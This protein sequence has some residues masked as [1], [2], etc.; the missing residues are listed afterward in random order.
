MMESN[1]Y[2]DEEIEAHELR[3][4]L[5]HYRSTAVPSIVG[6]IPFGLALILA[7]VTWQSWHILYPGFARLQTL[8][9]SEFFHPSDTSTETEYLDSNFQ[10]INTQSEQLLSPLFTPQV[11]QWGDQIL[12]WADEFQLDPNLVAVVMQIESC[13]SPS[14]HSS[15]GA[16]GLFQVMPYHFDAHDDPY[17]PS[18]NAQT[19]LNYLARSFELASGQIDRTLAGYNGGHGVISLPSGQWSDETIRYVSWGTGI[20][21]EIAAGLDSSPTLEAW[22]AAGGSHLCNQAF[23]AMLAENE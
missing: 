19:G 9:L 16:V 6:W 14:A 1:F 20:L 23:T 4:R 5:Q 7:I 17:D 3:A 18:I 2:S 8:A 21:S 12:A 11:L 13:G 10:E 22:L 15:A